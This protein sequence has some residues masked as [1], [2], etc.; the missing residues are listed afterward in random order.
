MKNYNKASL[1]FLS[2]IFYWQDNHHP[3]ADTIKNY[4]S[5]FNDYYIKNI[6]SRIRANTS[7]NATVESIIKQAYVIGIC[8]LINLHFIKNINYLILTFLILI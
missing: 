3:F 7:S 4:L 6:Y 1:V 8:I 5:C 2:D